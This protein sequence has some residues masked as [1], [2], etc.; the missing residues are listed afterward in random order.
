MRLGALEAGGTKMVLSVGDEHGV[1]FE[2]TSIPTL[3]PDVTIPEIIAYFSKQNICALGIGSFGPIELNSS[4]DHYGYLTTTPKREWVNYPMLPKLKQA[5]GVPVK[6]D[7]D[8]N[9]AAL[10]E[11][12][13]GAAKGLNSCLYVTVGTGVGGGIIAEGE[14]VHGLLHPELGHMLIVPSQDDP[15]PDGICSYHKH[16]LE[17]LASGA[18]MSKRWGIAAY[19]IPQ[20][21]PAWELETE[22]L[23]QMCANAILCFSPSRIILGGGVMHQAFLFQ[24][25]RARTKELLGGYVRH[26]VIENAIDAYIVP[27]GLGDDSGVVG[28]LILASEAV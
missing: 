18:S 22:Y 16:C 26:P 15:M 9:A 5:L 6:I 23:S 27:P 4:S 17:G 8:V 20:D 13:Y 12:R 24:R 11:H 2:R 7:T 10:A 1:V 21:H 14:L 3:E 28:A 19:E 25:I